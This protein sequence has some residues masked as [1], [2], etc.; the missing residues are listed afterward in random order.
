MAGDSR[1]M[2]SLAMRSLERDQE[3][4]GGEWVS[5]R[6]GHHHCGGQGTEGQDACCTGCPHRQ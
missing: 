3:K 1:V 2:Q 4:L 6:E 5:G